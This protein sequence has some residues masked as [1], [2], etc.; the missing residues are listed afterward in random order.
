M[1]RQWMDRWLSKSIERQ[2]LQETIALDEQHS[3]ILEDRKRWNKR[4]LEALKNNKLS[5]TWF[6]LG[7][8][9][10]ALLPKEFVQSSLVAE[11]PELDQQIENIYKYLPEK[12]KRL[13]LLEE[14][15]SRL[16]EEIV[17][18]LENQK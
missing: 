10:F 11:E 12:R 7:R 16:T 17:Q 3:E 8:E 15:I 6:S 1:P 9:S 14:E 13:E 18:S 4:A 2:K 5:D